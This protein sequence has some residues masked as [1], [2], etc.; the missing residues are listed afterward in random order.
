MRDE[1]DVLVKSDDALILSDSAGTEK[2]AG[3]DLEESQM[4]DI[5]IHNNN[6]DNGQSWMRRHCRLLDSNDEWFPASTINSWKRRTPYFILGG[7]KKAGML[8][9]AKWW[10]NQQL[11]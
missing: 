2:K 3:G 9:L 5:G 8:S 4:N 1:G 7:A 11:Q 6:N 10:L